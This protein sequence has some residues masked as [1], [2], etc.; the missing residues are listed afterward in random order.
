MALFLDMHWTTDAKVLGTSLRFDGVSKFEFDAEKIFGNEVV[1]L[2]SLEGEEV[3]GGWCVLG[4]CRTM[5]S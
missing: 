1:E 3:R 4:R 2:I 5:S